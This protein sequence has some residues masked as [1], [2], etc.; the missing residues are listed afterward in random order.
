MGE[1]SYFENKKIENIIKLFS[2]K[3][4]DE[5]KKGKKREKAF[6]FTLF[7]FLDPSHSCGPTFTF[8]TPMLYLP[9]LFL[10]GPTA[11]IVCSYYCTLF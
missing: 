2:L 5:K 10:L 9:D 6:I 4:D 3:N 11:Q 7:L 8:Y 1:K